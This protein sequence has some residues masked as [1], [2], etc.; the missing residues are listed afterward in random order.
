MAIFK[1]S[2]ERTGYE[3]K[4]FWTFVHNNCLNKEE[5]YLTQTWIDIVRTL[6]LHA[7]VNHNT[8]TMM[9]SRLMQSERTQNVIR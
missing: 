4:R 8:K 5:F 6:N 1:N 7:S 2:Y 9:P 3:S